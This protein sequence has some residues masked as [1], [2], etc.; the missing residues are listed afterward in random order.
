MKLSI[1]VTI[2]ENN[3]HELIK[4]L[5]DYGRVNEEDVFALEDVRSALEKFIQN[6][7]ESIISD[8]DHHANRIYEKS[9]LQTVEECRMIDEAD[10]R[11]SDPFMAN[12]GWDSALYPLPY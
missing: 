10:Y 2:D 5:R 8:L 1:T 6:E 11:I 4:A 7:A 3:L 9:D 12:C